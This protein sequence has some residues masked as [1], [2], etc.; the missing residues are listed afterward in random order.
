MSDTIRSNDLLVGMEQ[1]VLSNNYADNCDA[2]PIPYEDFQ[3]SNITS[4]I[5]IF[6]VGDRNN[7]HEHKFGVF[8]NESV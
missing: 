7:Y 5:H 6:A 8:F 2:L 3:F 4:T 1:F